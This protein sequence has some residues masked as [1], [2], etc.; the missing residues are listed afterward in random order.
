MKYNF[1]KWIKAAAVRAIK[2][3]AQTAIATIGT[4]AVIREV[5]WVMV[6]SA[7]ALAGILSILTSVAG[8]PEVESK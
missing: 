3:V 1:K 2:T 5:D 6:A 7:S 8:L 4:T